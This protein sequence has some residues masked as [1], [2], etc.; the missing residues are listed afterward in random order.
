MDEDDDEETKEEFVPVYET[1]Q[2]QF[3]ICKVP[4]RELVFAQ[5]KRKAGAAILFYD[6][7]KTYLETLRLFN[8]AT[9]EEDETQ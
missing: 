3:E 1:A 2:V 7:A 4:D 5:F 9:L 6:S 8:N